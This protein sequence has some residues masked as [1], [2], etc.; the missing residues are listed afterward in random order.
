MY[1][2]IY[3]YAMKQCKPRSRIENDQHIETTKQYYNFHSCLGFGESLKQCKASEALVS[4]FHC[5]IIKTY[6]YTYTRIY[7]HACTY[8]YM[9]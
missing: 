4:W 9:H 3:V 1:V 7:Q 8:I 2:Y 6:K 5:I